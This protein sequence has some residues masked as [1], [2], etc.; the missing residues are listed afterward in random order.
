MEVDYK[1][2]KED[3]IEFL[4]SIGEDPEDHNIEQ[5]LEEGF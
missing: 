1:K 4:E 5:L 3:V 2:T